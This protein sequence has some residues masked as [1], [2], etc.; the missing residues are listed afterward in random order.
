MTTRSG[1]FKY[2]ISTLLIHWCPAI[3]S[4]WFPLLCI[5][6]RKK[7]CLLVLYYFLCKTL[8]KHASFMSNICMC[9]LSLARALFN[10]DRLCAKLF[11]NFVSAIATLQ[12]V[13]RL[14]RSPSWVTCAC[15]AFFFL[16][17]PL[18]LLQ[19]RMWTVHTMNLFLLLHKTETSEARSGQAVFV[20]LLLCVLY[21]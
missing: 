14:I 10:L 19:K 11:K 5:A 12:S 20:F 7:D 18:F 21:V 2:K 15:C 1:F 8:S 16:P 9:V 3:R 17:P 6:N 13:T 4:A